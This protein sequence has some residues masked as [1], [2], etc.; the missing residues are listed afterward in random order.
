MYKWAKLPFFSYN[1]TAKRLQILYISS[2]K[3]KTFKFKSTLEETL[4][5]FCLNILNIWNQPP[6][7]KF[8]GRVKLPLLLFTFCRQFSDDFYSAI[9]CNVIIAGYFFAAFAPLRACTSILTYNFKLHFRCVFFF[10]SSS[11]N[12]CVLIHSCFYKNGQKL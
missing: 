5:F 8:G 3:K 1:I 7:S 11:S 2:S 10:F 4:N 9:P 12:L 6:S